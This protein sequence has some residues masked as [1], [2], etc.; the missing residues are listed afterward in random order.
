MSEFSW[1][2]SRCRGGLRIPENEVHMYEGLG[3]VRFADFMS[4]VLNIP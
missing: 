2:T 4:F 3:F 1:Y